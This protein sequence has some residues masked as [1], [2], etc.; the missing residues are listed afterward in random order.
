[1]IYFFTDSREE[2]ETNTQSNET[3]CESCLLSYE[4][5]FLALCGEQKMRQVRER[6]RSAVCL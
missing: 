1:M 2:E 6:T 4:T 5:I 3:A